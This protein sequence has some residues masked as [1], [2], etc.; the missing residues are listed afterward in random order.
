MGQSFYQKCATSSLKKYKKFLEH[1]III[2][3]I[4]FFLLREQGAGFDPQCPI[5]RVNFFFMNQNTRILGKK[6]NY[7]Y[8]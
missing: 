2:E 3:I 7:D 4:S 1:E 6:P 8:L 5:R